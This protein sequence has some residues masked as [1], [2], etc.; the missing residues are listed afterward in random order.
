L[1]ANFETSIS[2]SQ[3][4]GLKPGSFQALK[5]KFETGFSLHRLKR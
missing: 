4:Q 1:K 3:A 2:T 5:A